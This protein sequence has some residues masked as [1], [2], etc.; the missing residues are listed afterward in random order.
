MHNVNKKIC[1]SRSRSSG[2]T[3]VEVMVAFLILAIGLLGTAY[4]QTR[5]VQYGNESQN[6]SQ[7]NIV[8]SEMIDRMRS[9]MIQATSAS[10]TLYTAAITNAE[11]LADQCAVAPPVTVSVRDDTICFLKQL[12][13]MAPASNMQITTVDLDNDTN[14]DNYQITVYWSDQQL[15]QGNLD[16]DSDEGKISESDCI[17]L[18]REWSGDLTWWPGR[19]DPELCLVSHAWQFEVPI[20]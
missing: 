5:S 2:F 15:S 13:V 17:D 7:I 8:V 11:L 12:I 14:I 16:E 9:N 4:L 19:I 18:N 1:M 3:F 6:R 10:S 20:R